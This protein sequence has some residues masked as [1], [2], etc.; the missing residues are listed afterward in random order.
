MCGY[1]IQP[2]RPFQGNQSSISMGTRHL[3]AS[4]FFWLRMIQHCLGRSELTDNYRARAAISIIRQMSRFSYPGTEAL[5]Q[6]I[7][8]SMNLPKA[9]EVELSQKY[10]L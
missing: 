7:P 8:T 5:L 3:R 4:N 9:I 2:K 1:I 6:V 10:A